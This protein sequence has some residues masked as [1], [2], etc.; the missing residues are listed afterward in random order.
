VTKENLVPAG[1]KIIQPAAS[2]FFA[3]EKVR[4]EVNE[5]M[6]F[7]PTTFWKLNHSGSFFDP[8]DGGAMFL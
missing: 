1:T 6:S 8:E 2:Y 5:F 3:F 4:N 7:L